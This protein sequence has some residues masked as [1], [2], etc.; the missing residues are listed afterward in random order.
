MSSH[1]WTPS[2]LPDLHGRRAVVTGAGRASASRPCSS[3]PGTA[4]TS[5]WRC[6]TRRRATGRSRRC[7]AG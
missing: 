7:A 3:S 5:S 1:R 4:S 2:D 6:A